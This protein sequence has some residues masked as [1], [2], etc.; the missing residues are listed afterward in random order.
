MQIFKILG[1]QTERGDA[2]FVSNRKNE[3]LCFLGVAKFEVAESRSFVSNRIWRF[4][5]RAVLEGAAGIA[6]GR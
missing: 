5:G 4:C 6:G 1:R 3:V 2:S